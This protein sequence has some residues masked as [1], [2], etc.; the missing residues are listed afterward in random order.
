MN[1]KAMKQFDDDQDKEYGRKKKVKH[2]RNLPGKGMRIINHYEDEYDEY[3]LDLDDETDL[4][5]EVVKNY[6]R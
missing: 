1:L 5:D 2:S 3:F 4:S 6:R